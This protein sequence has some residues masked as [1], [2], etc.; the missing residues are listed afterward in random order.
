MRGS[1]SA[2]APASG[3]RSTVPCSYATAFK[4]AVLIPGLDHQLLAA[5]GFAGQRSSSA[6]PA[7]LP[8]ATV[9]P[10]HSNGEVSLQAGCTSSWACEHKRS[11]GV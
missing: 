10:P 4:P 1:I 9:L 2:D 8:G 6:Q 11:P 3:T 7:Q 5:P